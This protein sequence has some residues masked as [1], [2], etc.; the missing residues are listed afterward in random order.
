MNKKTVTDIDVKGKRVLVRVDF[1]VPLDLKSGT[2]TND[3]RIRAALPT[4]R[5]LVDNSAKVILCTH[6]GRPDG[7]V[8]E[9]LRVKPLAARL[10]QLM[11]VPV[12]VAP[13]C[14]GI[15]VEQAVVSLKEGDILLLE[16][17]R[18]HPEEEAN[19]PGFARALANLA[20]IYV[21]DAF[22][23]AHRAHASTVGVAKYIPAVA[24]LLME[25]E[26][27]A[28]SKI[29]ASPEHP[30]A[31]L[32][33]GAKVGDKIGLLQSILPKVDILLI[34]GGMA[35]LFLK[36]KGYQVGA[37]SVEVD[38]LETA[39]AIIATA[40]RNGTPVLLPADVV[41]TTD[42][43]QGTR[44]RTA[45]VTEISSNEHIVDI[46]PKTVRVFSKELKRC[47]TIFWNGPMGIY[48]IPAFA[49]GTK[50]IAEVLANIKATTIIGGGSTAEV[51]ED[52]G[53]ADKMSHV[54]TGGGASLKFLEGK[55]L[56]GVA[57]LLDKEP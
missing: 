27:T 35:S 11:G 46:G 33:G 21:N 37:S 26:L 53:L 8:I 3:S 48:E 7:K 31:A 30:F 23:T 20:D 47:R 9:E 19:D 50:A 32:L 18:F 55:T 34:G 51:V 29:L 49:Q 2:I 13:D 24:G 16:N 36:A 4:I 22:G 6:L 56:P 40:S 10:S 38:R 44:S 42:P 57:V 1:N 17:V 28:L 15:E 39:N 14:V 25:K 52:M 12:L 45:P 43:K 54:S 41:V 5:Y